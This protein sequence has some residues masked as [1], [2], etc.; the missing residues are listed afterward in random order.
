MFALTSRRSRRLTTAL[1]AA[2]TASALF[3]IP[4]DNVRASGCAPVAFAPAWDGYTE[5]SPQGTLPC[6]G[7]WT[8][9]LATSGGTSLWQTSGTGS[10]SVPRDFPHWVP[11]HGSYVHT[12]LYV[13]VNGTGMSDTSGN[14]LC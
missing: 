5:A 6:S 13:N 12:W 4:H 11:C 9:R 3:T 8:I 7:S 1:V 2:A 14:I 10:G